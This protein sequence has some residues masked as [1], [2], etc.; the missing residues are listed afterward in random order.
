[1][2]TLSGT[3]RVWLALW[4]APLVLAAWGGWQLSRPS[5]TP[6]DLSLPQAVITATH[7][8]AAPTTTGRP[9]APAQFLGR[10]T[11]TVLR[12]PAI[13]VRASVDAKGLN[14]DGTLPVPSYADIGRTDWYSGAASPGEQGPAVIVGHVDSKTSA[15]VFFNLRKLR[16]GDQIM[17]QRRD[18]RTAAFAVDTIQQVPKNDFP[19]AAVYGM[20]DRAEIRLITCGGQF[21]PKS[22]SYRDNIVVY[23]SLIDIRQ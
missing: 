11:P 12:I 16:P 13:G 8:T 23:G 9:T 18:G 19:S 3:S 15:G 7:S 2:T 5:P 14:A 17:V 10:S 21:D 22:G 4:I 6:P 20:T 1:M